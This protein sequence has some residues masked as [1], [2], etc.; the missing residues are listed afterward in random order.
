MSY[1][2][3]VDKL[4]NVFL[5]LHIFSAAHSDKNNLRKICYQ[6]RSSADCWVL[7][8][9]KSLE[10]YDLLRTSWCDQGKY[11]SFEVLKG[12]G[13]NLFRYSGINAFILM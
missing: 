4:E 2:E 6:D 7:I 11:M 1:Y 10:R 12:I 5:G 9:I 8:G 3:V 13:M